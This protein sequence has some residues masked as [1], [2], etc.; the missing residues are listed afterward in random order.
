[1]SEKPQSKTVWLMPAKLSMVV[2]F[3]VV[4]T[5]WL[6]SDP[7]RRTYLLFRD[8]QVQD[9]VTGSL[10]TL[11]LPAAMVIISKLRGIYGPKGARF[12]VHSAKPGRVVICAWWSNETTQSESPPSQDGQPV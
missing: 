5:K 12:S 2:V 8:D 1:M 6:Q 7:T 10:R 9:P 4:L 11:P 3:D